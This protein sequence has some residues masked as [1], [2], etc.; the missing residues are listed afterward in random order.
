MAG[1]QGDRNAGGKGVDFGMKILNMKLQNFMG[2]RDLELNLNGNDANIWGTNA[3]G[4]TTCFSAFTW[5]M[6][7]K[8]S[9]NRSDFEI[10]TLGPDGEPEHGLEHIVEAVL[11]LAEAIA[12]KLFGDAE[13]EKCEKAVPPQNV[14]NGIDRSDVALRRLVSRLDEINTRL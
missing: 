8:D 7:G 10:K 1:S 3:A 9:L 4:K 6:F 11:E 12:N 5:L 13:S 2:I 14:Q